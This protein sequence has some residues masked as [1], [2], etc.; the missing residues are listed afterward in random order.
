MTGLSGWVHVAAG[1][2]LL[3]GLPTAARA[4]IV[5]PKLSSADSAHRADFYI[6]RAPFR[7][8]GN[9]Y[10]VGTQGLSA[11][12]I[13]SDSGDVLID[14]T[15]AEA[16][17]QILAN[18]RQLGFDPRN[19]KLI[20][21]S[22]THYDH[23]GGIAAI[24]RVTGAAVAASPWS[25]RVLAAGH[26]LPGD[27]QFGIVD[28]FPAV[29]NV[30]VLADGEVMRVGPIALTAH[31]TPGHTPG[32][33]SWTWRSCEAG[34]CLDLVYADSQTPAAAD[35]FLFTNNSSYPQALQDFAH[36]LSVIS[37]LPCDILL[38]AHPGVSRL[39]ERLAAR[40]SGNAD[41]LIDGGAC[42]RMVE[43]ARHQIAKRVARERVEPPAPAEAVPTH[44]S[45]T[46]RSRILKEARLINVHTP[47]G[48]SATRGPRLPVL[49]MPDGGIDEDFPHVVNTVDSLIALG[50]IR[51][52]IVVGI[53]NT[54]RRRDLTGP[55][56][57]ASD[58]AIA[59]SVGGSAAF[60]RFISDELFPAI[61]RRYRV[62]HERSI[63]G[64]SLAGLF[65][66]ETFLRAPDLFQHY[67]AFDPSLWWNK[68]ALTDS[69]RA[70]AKRM[71]DRPR[72][73]FVAGSSDGI[74]G[75]TVFADSLRAAR[76][77]RLD[78]TYSERADLVHPTIF[79]GSAPAALVQALK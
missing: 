44:D 2:A 73:L 63:V 46:V 35:G 53:P 26:S 50:R 31:F 67:I 17:G 11:I 43:E 7:I 71:D 16:A 56:R 45:F 5:P 66:V 70:F 28:P 29:A 39:W 40:D 72:A 3:A 30:R 64:E 9:T 76:P 36:G 19:V 62:T 18:I 54:Q 1:G 37:D 13:T 8:Y 15:V 6:A 77:R 57:I 68:G 55:T 59:P 38:T 23:A 25:A 42:K 33:T 27:P 79:R 24:Q 32:G 52:V 22:H 10:F 60:R 78:F 21:N 34:R 65:I 14:G 41:A 75:T 4:Q 12:L 51:P 47:R 58:S 61:D 48:Y 69:V 20:L 49:Y 74:P